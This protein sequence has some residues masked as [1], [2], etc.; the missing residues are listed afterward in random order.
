MVRP[1][2]FPPPAPV[3]LK[4]EPEAIFRSSDH[5]VVPYIGVRLVAFWIWLFLINIAGCTNGA[6]NKMRELATMS[7][8]Q[9]LS[10][11]KQERARLYE[12]YGDSAF[13]RPE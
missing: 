7:T 9:A 2:D 12:R 13:Q 10:E 3:N 11:I 5:R 6:E 8:A 4:D 1:I